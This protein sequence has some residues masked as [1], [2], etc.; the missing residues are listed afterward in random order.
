M[1][2]V[3]RQPAPGEDTLAQILDGGGSSVGDLTGTTV[4]DFQV[5][6]LIGRGGMGEVYLAT[7]VSLNR[8]V[9][10]KVLRPDVMAKPGYQKRFEAE[11]ISV[12]KLNHPSIVHVY[13]MS[14]IGDVTYIAMEYV[15]GTNLREYVRKRG[16]LDVLQ[17][18]SIMKQTAQAIGAAAEAGLIHRDV[19]PEN[20]LITRRGR[21][22][23][24]DFGLCRQMDEEGSHLTQLGTTMGTPAYMSPEQAQG[25]PLDH[26]SDLYS[27]G[28]TYYFMLAGVQPFRADSPVALALKQVREIPSSLI[29]HRPDLP[30]EID[31]LVMK[32]MAKNP[33]DR[34]QSAAEMLADLAKLRETI[35]VPPGSAAPEALDGAFARTEEVGALATQGGELA[36]RPHDP[37]APTVVEARRGRP[38]VPTPAAAPSR[39]E[40]PAEPSGSPESHRPAFS[41]MIATAAMALGLCAGAL[42]GWTARAPD[43]LSTPTEPSRRPPGLWIEPRWTAIPKQ[44][45]SAEDQLRYA[46]LQAPRD[47]LAA[48]WLAVPGNF[49]HSHDASTKAYVQLARLWY[50]Q[51]DLES[52]STLGTELS[53]WKE[54]QQRDKDLAALIVLAIQLKKGDLGAVEKGFEKLTATDVADMFEPALVAMSLE[55]CSDALQAVR[56][57]RNQTI[58]EPLRRTLRL[59]W[60]QLNHIE[61]GEA[62][63]ALR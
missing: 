6:R 1:S 32:L 60:R 21:V 22:K 13:A 20:I 18:W 62:A 34:Y 12:A 45:G 46:Q 37:P 49:P 41:G 15:E 9:A 17:A 36:L 10:L 3:D 4:G 19:K 43:V 52:L 58:E 26:R 11:A 40:E 8:P 51:D 59:L 31:R 28:A 39:G 42:A 2:P 24:A 63:G 33:G 48:A 16:A 5:E 55:V 44:P 25:H 50:R 61:I 47:E 23:V 14:T 27:L 29:L 54:A 56:K 53:A 38:V 57:S 35:Q 7:Q 30:L